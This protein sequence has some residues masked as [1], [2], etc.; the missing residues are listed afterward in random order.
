M[1]YL[2]HIVE[3]KE[4]Y[5]DTVQMVCRWPGACTCSL[6]FC[7][8]S[9]GHLTCSQKG[10]SNNNWH[11]RFT[12][13]GPPLCSGLQPS[14]HPKFSLQARVTHIRI[15]ES[16]DYC[17]SE[18]GPQTVTGNLLKM[19]NPALLK[20]NLHFKKGSGGQHVDYGFLNTN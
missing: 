1:R 12:A 16:E 19:K 18:C 10:K 4:V 15:K 6:F 7:V 20:W 11:L 5:G 2:L 8:I 14:F 9:V 3:S 17:Y 13:S